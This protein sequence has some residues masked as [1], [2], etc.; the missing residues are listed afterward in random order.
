MKKAVALASNTLFLTTVKMR[1]MFYAF[2]DVVI[3]DGTVI[4]MYKLL[5]NKFPA[6]KEDQA[7]AKLN[8]VMS[9]FGK[10]PTKIKLSSQRQNEGKLLSISPWVSGR[11]LLIDLGSPLRSTQNTS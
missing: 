9:V 2:Q 8:V 11:L 7:A 10:T 4:I 6:C 5:K 3:A 1:P